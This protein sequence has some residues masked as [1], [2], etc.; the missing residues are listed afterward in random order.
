MRTLWLS[1]KPPR[2]RQ[3]E[4]MAAHLVKENRKNEG[5]NTVSRAGASESARFA[6]THSAKFRRLIH[7]SRLIS[8]LPPQ[9]KALI[10]F[11]L[12]QQVEGEYSI[13]AAF[14]DPRLYRLIL[15]WHR[16]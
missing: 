10:C 8:S 2:V 3:S 15:C 5:A 16:F 1:L 11:L 12:A 4:F 13:Q 14:L 6:T 7:F 9:G